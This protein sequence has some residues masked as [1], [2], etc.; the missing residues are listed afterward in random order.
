MCV[1]QM[2]TIFIYLVFVAEKDFHKGCFLERV[3]KSKITGH[4]AS[5]LFSLKN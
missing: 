4:A 1:A 2:R 3:Q 5:A